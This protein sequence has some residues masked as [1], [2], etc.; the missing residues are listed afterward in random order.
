MYGIRF[1]SRSRLSHV[2]G[3][4]RTVWSQMS[5]DDK[6]VKQQVILFLSRRR[7]VL[8]EMHDADGISDG[9]KCETTGTVNGRTTVQRWVALWKHLRCMTF[10]EDSTLACG[11]TK[12]QEK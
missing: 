1:C 11:Q 3:Y 6:A 10:S 5:S 8:S 12:S 4:N 7:E 2:T 9:R